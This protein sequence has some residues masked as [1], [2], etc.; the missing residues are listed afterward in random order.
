MNKN[1]SHQLCHVRQVCSTYVLLLSLLTHQ[2]RDGPK[3]AIWS[4]RTQRTYWKTWKTR[5]TSMSMV[6]PL[7]FPAMFVWWWG[8]AVWSVLC[9]CFALGP[10]GS[11]VA[12][13]MHVQVLSSMLKSL[14]VQH[15]SSS[16]FPSLI[17]SSL[18]IIRADLEP[19]KEALWILKITELHSESHLMTGEWDKVD[20]FCPLHAI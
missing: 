4:T 15:S 9:W 10:T 20:L 7:Q 6:F 16:F 17:T 5:Q 12:P 14:A 19:K 11:T 2:G 1:I 13:L 8:M 18:N 3:G